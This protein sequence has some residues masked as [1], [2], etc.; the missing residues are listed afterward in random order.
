MTRDE[1]VAHIQMQLGFRTTLSSSIISQLQLAQQNLETGPTLP[2]FLISEDSYIR[3]EDGEQRVPLPTD[4]LEEADEAV[5]RY[6]PDDLSAENPEVDL[7]RDEYDVLRKNYMDTATGT[8]KT[9]P[10]EA[11]AL[12]GEY[13]RVFPTPD[14]DYLIRMIYYQ[15]D[16]LLT[17]NIENQWLKYI[18]KL[19]MGLAGKQLSGGPLRD[20]VAFSTF[21]AWEKEGRAMLLSKEIRRDISNRNL[22]VGGPH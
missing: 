19:L 1:A 17:T 4:F 18:P 2:W 16:D 14:D 13:F 20:Q 5:L 8:I 22:Q 6:I 9:G 21:D 7:I 10:P 12:F 15:Q 3:T 11:Y